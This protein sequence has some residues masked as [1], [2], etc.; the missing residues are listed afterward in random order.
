MPKDKFTAVWISHSSIGDYLKCPRLYYLRAV[1]KDPKTGH[2]I[3]RMQPPLA[4]GQAVHDV[5]QA[6][7]TLPVDLRLKEPLLKKFDVA[8]EKVAGK[9]GGFTSKGEEAKY[10]QRGQAMIQRIIDNPGPILKK[11]IRTRE[12]LPNYWLSEEDNLILCGKIDWLQ[13]NEED[14]S[15]HLL[16]FKTGK[17]DEDGDSLQ[18]PIY[19]LLA[20]NCQKRKVNGA[21]YWYLER[22]NA[23]TEVELPQLTESFER[24]L[25]I[26]KKIALARKLDHFK[27]QYPGGCA[28]CQPLESIVSGNGELVG[29]SEYNQDIYVL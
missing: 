4:L 19:N 8:W 22:D 13:Y 25:E 12:E 15:V 11:A 21:S 5:V 6:L 16:D 7:S 1:Y 24:V 26:G 3:T 20:T 29:C 9:K 28:A 10:K 2:K 23:P 14:D 17:H 27:C 18:L